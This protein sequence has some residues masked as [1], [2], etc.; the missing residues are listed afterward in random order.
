MPRGSRGP[1][2]EAR[3][4]RVP[5]LP[6]PDPRAMSPKRPARSRPLRLL[7]LALLLAAGCAGR[8][9][10][11]DRAAVEAMVRD[12]RY[13]QAVELAAELRDAAPADESLAELHRTATIALYL[14]AARTATLEDRDLDA[15]GWIAKGLEVEPEHPLLLQWREKTRS[16]VATRLVRTGDALF[17][18]G[19]LEGAAASYRTVLVYLPDHPE[20]REGLEQVSIVMAYREGL[21]A[22]YY[23]DG[24]RAL[25][26]YRL[27]QARRGFQAT[28]KYLP[29]NDRAQR[30]EGVVDELLAEQRIAI[31]A[32]FEAEGLYAAAHNEYRFALMLDPDSV[33]A[34]D[35]LARL[36]TEAEAARLLREAQMRIYRRQLNQARELIEEGAE[37][38]AQQREAFDELVAKIEDIRLDELYRRAFDLERDGRYPLAIEAYDALLD[39]ADYFLDA[40]ARRSTLAGYVEMA[41]GYW[42]DYLEAKERDEKLQHLRSIDGFWPDYPGLADAL[43]ALEGEGGR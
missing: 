15:L 11:R 42:Q 39:E 10:A 41:D 19:D 28:T 40:A 3:A 27:R 22:D 43:E 29:G 4:P 2:E 17:T 14:D 37:L 32:G 13:E 35:G 12:G 30:R 5:S 33:E 8:Q 7:P 31:A 9:E 25:S 23:R 21:G 18:Q 6:L 26:D 38:S 20:A 24:V 16:K 36:E 34:Q 1:G